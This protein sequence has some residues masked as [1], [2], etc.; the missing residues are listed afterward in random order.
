MVDGT[1]GFFTDY[2]IERKIP[3]TEMVHL[4]EAFVTSDYKIG[5]S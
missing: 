3:Y 4:A 2:T 1:F 5:E